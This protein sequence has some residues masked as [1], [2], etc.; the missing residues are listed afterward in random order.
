MMPATMDDA[1]ANG[2]GSENADDAAGGDVAD[3]PGLP[4]ANAFVVRFAAETDARLEHAGGRVEHLQSGRRARFASTAN[5]VACIALL[6]TDESVKRAGPREEG[7][8]PRT[9]PRKR[10][11]PPS[12][13]RR[14]P[15]CDD[16][17]QVQWIALARRL[18][19][20]VRPTNPVTAVPGVEGR[21]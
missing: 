8:R 7:Q 4:Y 12:P 16:L 6:L 11:E 2:S 10:M 13:K 18:R 17:R 19:E 15:V 1:V 14:G 5:L 21:R 3:R 9:A 20:V